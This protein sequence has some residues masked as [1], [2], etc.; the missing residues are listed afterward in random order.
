MRISDWSS[1]V[2]SSDLSEE[3]VRKLNG[4][5]PIDPRE[6]FSSPLWLRM[7]PHMV[8]TTTEEVTTGRNTMVRITPRRSDERRVGKEC[9]RTCRVRGVPDNSKKTQTRQHH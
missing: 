5:R 6:E 9:G 7:N 4:P 1:D 8:A 3:S 2:C